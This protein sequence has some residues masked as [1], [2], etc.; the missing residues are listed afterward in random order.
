MD[1]TVPILNRMGHDTKDPKKE[2]MT[3]RYNQCVERAV[4]LGADLEEIERQRV[5]Y[6]AS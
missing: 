2:I 5:L 4:A 6:L 3:K 1:V